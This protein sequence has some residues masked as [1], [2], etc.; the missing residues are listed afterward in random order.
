MRDR[1]IA[2]ESEFWQRVQNQDAPMV[3][4]DDISLIEYSMVPVEDSKEIALLPEHARALAMEYKIAGD[5]EKEAKTAKDDAKAQLCQLLAGHDK[6][7]IGE[8]TI[9]WTPV[10]TNR[11]DT[12]RLKKEK[13]EVYQEYCKSDS[14]RRFS[15]K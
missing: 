7:K 8:F 4:G 6:G 13:P 14:S 12:D 9:N 11:L 10:S 5:T 15:I 1:V 2:I 3:T